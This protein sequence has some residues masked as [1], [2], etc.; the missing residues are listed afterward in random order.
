MFLY[1]ETFVVPPLF[2]VF[3]TTLTPIVLFV[4]PKR[5][6]GL[7]CSPLSRKKPCTVK[8]RDHRSISLLLGATR[9]ERTPSEWL[10]SHLKT[11][12][13]TLA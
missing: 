11:W 9:L 4:L 7:G 8:G 5:S 12:R 13:F 10:H 6:S 3:V 2:Y 1:P